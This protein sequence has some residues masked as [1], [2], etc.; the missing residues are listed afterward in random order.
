MTRIIDSLSDI[1]GKYDALFVDLWG[2]VHDGVRA[3]PAAVAAL[4]EYSAKGGKVVLVTNS[5]KP[6]A[7]VADQLDIFG[8]ARDSWD[9]IASSGDSARRF[10][11]VDTK[12]ITWMS[13]KVTEMNQ[14]QALGSMGIMRYQRTRATSSETVG[15]ASNSFQDFPS[16]NRRKKYNPTTTTRKYTHHQLIASVNTACRA[17][18][19]SAG[20][21]VSRFSV[22]ARFLRKAVCMP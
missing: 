4:Q 3:L 20:E 12:S 14:N 7:G 6:R 1:S 10:N 21:S 13:T 11:L 2:C 18:S 16:F 17:A 15:F 22:P 5:P 19:R 9:T 8:V